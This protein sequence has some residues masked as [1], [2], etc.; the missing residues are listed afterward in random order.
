MLLDHTDVFM[1]FITEVA[2]WHQ[3][4]METGGNNKV[5]AGMPILMTFDDEIHLQL[6]GLWRWEDRDEETS[7]WKV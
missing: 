6:G 4:A 1:V 5:D 3:E 2:S 7:V